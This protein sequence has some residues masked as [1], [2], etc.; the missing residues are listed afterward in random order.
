MSHT[1][2]VSAVSGRLQ[3]RRWPR[4]ACGTS[5]IRISC[6]SSVS[7]RPAASRAQ[8]RAQIWFQP[9]AFIP[10]SLT[11]SLQRPTVPSAA[12]ATQDALA[13]P[14]GVIEYLTV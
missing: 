14:D 12:N 13:R 4:Q 6:V 2:H 5:P 11:A 10:A 8:F 9:Q 7:D 3:S 1:T